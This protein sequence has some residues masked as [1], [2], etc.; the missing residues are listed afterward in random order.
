MSIEKEFLAYECGYEN[1]LD[2][3]VGEQQKEALRYITAEEKKAHAIAAQLLLV[4]NNK[5]DA[6]TIEDV[7]KILLKMHKDIVKNNEVHAEN[8]IK[9]NN[10]HIKI[11]EFEE[12][13]A[14][15]PCGRCGK[16]LEP[17]LKFHCDFCAKYFDDIYRSKDN[18]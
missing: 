5:V 10:A 8:L 2:D 4:R 7:S 15:K 6:Q 11:A 14:P 18:A 13:L 16:K 17:A 3:V 9:L 12:F 1:G